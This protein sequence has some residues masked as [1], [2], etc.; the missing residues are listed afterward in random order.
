MKQEG[1]EESKEARRGNKESV[2]R[3]Q[4]TDVQQH[5]KSKLSQRRALSILVLLRLG[6]KEGVECRQVRLLQNLEREEI[7]EGNT[8]SKEE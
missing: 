6:K 7:T 1:N 4:I 8:L 2:I 5:I 3:W